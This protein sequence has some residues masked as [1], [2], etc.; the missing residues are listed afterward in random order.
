MTFNPFA[1]KGIPLNEQFLTWKQINTLPYNKEQVHPFTRAH[2][3]LLNA[4]ETEAVFFLHMLLSKTENPELR[5]EISLLCRAEQ[6]QQKQINWLIPFQESP[7]EM[8][9]C[10][11]ATEAGLASAIAQN[12]PDDRILSALEFI[13]IEDIDHLYRFSNLYQYSDETPADWLVRNLLE[14]FPGRPSVI[15]HRHPIDTVCA[16]IDF[17]KSHIK[18]LIN[19]LLISSLEFQTNNFLSNIGNRII[20][21]EGRALF[22]EIAQVE[23]QHLTIA[24]SLIDPSFPAIEML[25]LIQYTEC[26]LYHSV[27]CSENDER[28]REIWNSNL[29]FE[30]GHLQFTNK[31][32]ERYYEKNGLSEIYPSEIPELAILFPHKPYLRHSEVYQIRK[33]LENGQFIPMWESKKM[34]RYHSFLKSINQN[35]VP[36]QKII[37]QVIERNGYDY[38]VESEG[39]HPVR[40]FRNRHIVPA[41]DELLEN[42]HRKDLLR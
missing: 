10:Y 4:L 14:I 17:S 40:L 19:C 21:K 37:E 20:D 25:M 15:S 7:V 2:I 22:Q 33:N 18:T 13:M 23:E 26:Y 24:N 5:K 16:P 30:I 1:E 6:Q 41:Q 8:A 34:D 32:I 12:E 39:D 28:I 31:L 11:E 29:Q 42:F 3:I 35:F 9:I 38:R 36:S 27:M